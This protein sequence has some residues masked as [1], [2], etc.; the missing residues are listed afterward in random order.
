MKRFEL[1]S[2]LYVE[3]CILILIVLLSVSIRFVIISLYI[4]NTFYDLIFS[5]VTVTFY[6]P[7]IDVVT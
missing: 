4:R 2:Y 5:P 3:Y 7:T 6:R 1:L